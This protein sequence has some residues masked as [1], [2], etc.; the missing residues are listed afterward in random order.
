MPFSSKGSPLP[1]HPAHSALPISSALFLLLPKNDFPSVQAFLTSWL[2]LT[3]NMGSFV[4]F[5][6]KFSASLAATQLILSLYF[7]N[8]ISHRG[9]LVG[10]FCY[11]LSCLARAFHT[12]PLHR[13]A[14]NWLLLGP[15][16]YD[17]GGQEAGR[18]PGIEHPRGCGGG[19]FWCLKM[20]QVPSPTCPIQHKKDYKRFWIIVQSVT[21]WQ[22]RVVF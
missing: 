22:A 6:C 4:T 8:L 21:S 14:L 12:W 19:I 9:I 16:G 13:L 10:F 7:L 11:D 15:V 3:S 18:L 17:G 20:R 5:L 2:L 1:S